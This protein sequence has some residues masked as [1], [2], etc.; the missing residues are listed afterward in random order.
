MTG[1][2]D[3]GSAGPLG[4]TVTELVRAVPALRLILDLSGLTGWDSV[5]LAG[6]ITAQDRIDAQ[7]GARMVVTGL[8]EHLRRRLDGASLDGGFTWASTPA[9]A[10]AI[11][12]RAT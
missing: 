1:R 11:F 4:G 3:L 12:S 10:L 2:L 7:P 9:A 6:L 5:G 8:P